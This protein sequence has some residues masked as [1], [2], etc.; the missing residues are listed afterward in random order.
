MKYPPTLE[1][2]VGL[3]DAVDAYAAVVHELLGSLEL[4]DEL[5]R[6]LDKLLATVTHSPLEL[7][8]K[9]LIERANDHL[10]ELT[11]ATNESLTA[12]TAKSA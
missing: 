2:D 5:Q 1:E 8:L 11:G 10:K 3:D 7:H 6:E 4:V 12:P 9:Y